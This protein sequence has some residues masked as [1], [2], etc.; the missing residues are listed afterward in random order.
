MWCGVSWPNDVGEIMGNL[1]KAQTRKRIEDVRI[2]AV[3]GMSDDLYHLMHHSVVG[4]VRMRRS[5]ESAD[6]AISSSEMAIAESKALL[7]R[8]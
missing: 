5:I 7:K 8:P 1:P 6:A 2:P 3:R 4:I